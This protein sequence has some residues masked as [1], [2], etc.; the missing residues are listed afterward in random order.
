MVLQKPRLKFSKHNNLTLF[1]LHLIFSGYYFF[2]DLKKQSEHS[3]RRLGTSSLVLFRN[4]GYFWYQIGNVG[5]S[6]FLFELQVHL[7]FCP[8]P[9]FFLKFLVRI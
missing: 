5:L 6:C 7:L 1:F 2:I 3:A 8:P 9:E 4:Y